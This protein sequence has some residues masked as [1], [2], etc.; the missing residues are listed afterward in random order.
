MSKLK[1]ECLAYV[2]WC[3]E[4]NL[5]PSDYKSLQAYFNAKNK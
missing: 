3:K 1:R 2:N 4:Q 5:K